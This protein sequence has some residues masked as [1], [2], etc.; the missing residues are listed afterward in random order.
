[1][2]VTKRQL[3]KIIKEEKLKI[4]NEVGMQQDVVDELTSAMDSIYMYVQDEIEFDGAHEGQTAEE[5]TKQLI[6]SEVNR[7]VETLTGID[8]STPRNL[9]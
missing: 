3:R 7:F 1:M 2:K 8:G 4:L 6:M 5:V 9:V